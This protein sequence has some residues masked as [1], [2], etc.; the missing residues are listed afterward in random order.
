MMFF[1]AFMGNLTSLT[2]IFMRADGKEEWVSEAPFIPGM[3]S[4][5]FLAIMAIH[6]SFA[7]PP[8][9]SGMA[10]TLAFDLLIVVQYAVYTRR[11]KKRRATRRLLREKLRK[12][13]G[14]LCCFP[15]PSL[16]LNAII[17]PSIACP[18]LRQ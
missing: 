6:P 7:L 5:P 2:S 1:C 14:R 9:T 16:A 10:G 13:K 11:A 8:V 12:G 15:C 4:A 18:C 17:G 3:M